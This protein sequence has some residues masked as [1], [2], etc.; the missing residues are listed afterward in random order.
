MSVTLHPL[1]VPRGRALRGRRIL[2]FLLLLIVMEDVV[3]LVNPGAFTWGGEEYVVHVPGPL[4]YPPRVADEIWD[5]YRITP[6]G[7]RPTECDNIGNRRDR[8]P[9][10]THAARARSHIVSP[11]EDASVTVPQ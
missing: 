10:H 2:L 3:D 1:P 5:R 11:S 4:A 7:W 6:I 9:S 8:T